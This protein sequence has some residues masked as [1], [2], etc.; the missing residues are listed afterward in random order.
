MSLLFVRWMRTND[1]MHILIT[2][3]AGYIG[4]HTAKSLARAGLQPVVL[5]NLQEDTVEPFNGAT[6]RGRYR[7]PQLTRKRFQEVS[8]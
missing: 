4:S 6:R 3:G 2:G 5:D 7:G 1:H 8:N